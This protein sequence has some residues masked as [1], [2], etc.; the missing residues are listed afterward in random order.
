MKT[1]LMKTLVGG[2][3]I[4]L[5]MLVMSCD[6]NPDITPDQDLLP[7][8]FRVDIPSSIANEDFVTNGRMRG[9]SKEDELN[10]NDIYQHLG[11]FIAIGDGAGELVE[12]LIGGI[13]KHQIN[14]VLSLSFISDDD[15][16]VKNMIVTSDAEFEGRTWQYQLTL[17]DAESEGN[18]DGGKALQV[19]WNH[20]Q[21]I[22]GISIIKL[23]NIDRTKHAD[24]GD[25]IFRIDYSEVSDQGYDAEMEVRIAG[26]PM[27]TPLEDPYAVSS[28]WMFAGKKGDVVDVY[29][30]SNHPNAIFFSGA[31]GFDWAFAASGDDANDIGVAEVGLPP[32]NLDSND[33]NELLVEN[34]IKN[35]FTNEINAVWPGLDPELLANYLQN[36]EAPGYFSSNGFIAGGES[37]GPAWDALAARITTLTPYSPLAVSNLTIQFK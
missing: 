17:T 7:D 29:G 11:T 31:V 30:N 6:T 21:P 23:Y 28:L 32:S 35:V 19:F 2:T 8:N 25:A 22:E 14:R 16:R 18:P 4:A 5:T 24:A 12:D 15:G 36:T 26:L 27:P 34:S 1:K 13:Q 37:P 33:R 10:G 9:R 3:F 20:Q